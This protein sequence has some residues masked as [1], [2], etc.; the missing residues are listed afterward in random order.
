MSTPNVSSASPAQTLLN[1][2]PESLQAA[3]EKT[4]EVVKGV[5][6]LAAG[7]SGVLAAGAIASAW[8][9]VGLPV[10]GT[11]A[12]FSVLTGSAALIAEAYLTSQGQGLLNK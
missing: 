6:N 8:T 11:A 9:G 12:A 5:R 3:H 7:A 1:I 2:S 10:A 4:I